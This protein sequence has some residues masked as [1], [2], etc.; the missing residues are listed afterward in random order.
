M[1]R[2]VDAV[3][4]TAGHG[5]AT[6]GEVAGDRCGR[7]KTSRGRP[8][9]PD[10][11]DRAHIGCSKLP[12]DEQQRRTVVDRP[13]IRRILVVENRE[14]VDALRLPAAD[15]DHDRVE[16]RLGSAGLEREQR[17]GGVLR[18]TGV[19]AGE[20]VDRASSRLDSVRVVV[21]P[22]PTSAQE[23][24]NG[25]GFSEVSP[26]APLRAY[27][28]IEAT[29]WIGR[30]VPLAAELSSACRTEPA[31]AGAEPARAQRGFRQTNRWP[32]ASPVRPSS[33]T[34]CVTPGYASSA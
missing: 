23:S 18:E 30:T 12:A 34:A 26:Y 6:V 13:R 9:S 10:D 29:D 31:R 28:R 17:W 14:H 15:F 1:R 16:I 32:R 22:A 21:P 19:A 7:G 2:G 25:C 4:Q 3:G 11:R 27:V 24:D 5:E 33:C 20:H 8:A